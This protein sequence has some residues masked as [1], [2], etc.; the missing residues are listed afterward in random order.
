MSEGK[1][2]V[3][4][5]RTW[6]ALWPLESCQSILEMHY[7]INQ[8]SARQGSLSQDS[9]HDLKCLVSRIMP[10]HSRD[11]GVMSMGQ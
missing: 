7:V 5:V 10:K 1:L 8:E 4:H 2:D 9:L 11:A 6:R 3:G